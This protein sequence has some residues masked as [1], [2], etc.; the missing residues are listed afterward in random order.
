[1]RR[2]IRVGQDDGKA[3]SLWRAGGVASSMLVAAMD[4]EGGSAR[5][6]ALSKGTI[7]RKRAKKPWRLVG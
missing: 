2:A 5:A 7:E 4:R 3:V 1:M 6:A